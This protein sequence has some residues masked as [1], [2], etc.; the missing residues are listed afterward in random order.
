[1]PPSNVLP[2]DESFEISD[3]ELTELALAADP[4]PVI[5]AAATSLWDLPGFSSRGPLPEWYMPAPMAPRPMTGWRRLV[6]RSN[7]LLVVASFLTITAYGLCNTYGQI[8]LG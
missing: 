3:E 1:M 4:D 8:H 5:D 2:R 7:A 6:V